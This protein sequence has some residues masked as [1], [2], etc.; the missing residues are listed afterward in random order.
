[1]PIVV[2]IGD[3]RCNNETWPLREEHYSLDVAYRLLLLECSTKARLSDH[4]H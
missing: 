3:E 1:M 2:C 4:S